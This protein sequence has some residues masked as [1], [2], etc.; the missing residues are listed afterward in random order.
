MFANQ[1]GN[2]INVNFTL[3]FKINIYICQINFTKYQVSFTINNI[4]LN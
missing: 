1:I 4:H 2:E 3:H